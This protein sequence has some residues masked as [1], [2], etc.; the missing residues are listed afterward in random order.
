MSRY[1]FDVPAIGPATITLDFTVAINTD[2]TEI[3]GDYPTEPGSRSVNTTQVCN[4]RATKVLN[5]V[6][7][8]FGAGPISTWVVPTD[9]FVVFRSWPRLINR[10]AYTDYPEQHGGGHYESLP[11]FRNVLT[12]FGNILNFAD[13]FPDIFFPP[14]GVNSLAYCGRIWP[15]GLTLVHTV[16]TT[17]MDFSD[18]PEPVE[19]DPVITNVPL[20]DAGVGRY[21]GVDFPGSPEIAWNGRLGGYDPL[22]TPLVPISIARLRT[23]AGG[24]D[25]GGTAN[26][27]RPEPPL[28]PLTTV[29]AVNAW[30]YSIDFTVTTA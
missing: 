6:P 13:S 21:I 7:F 1:L 24:I 25:I 14:D 23:L 28:S 12:Q 30:E 5:R 9:K 22:S 3:T 15:S 20:G 8:P 27:T 29:S 2:I 17:T 16:T 10:G 11:Y 26:Y 18:P 19:G 4:G